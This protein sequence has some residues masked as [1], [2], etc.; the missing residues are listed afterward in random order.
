MIRTVAIFSWQD[1]VGRVA[2]R[3]P[4]PWIT[5]NHGARGATRPTLTFMGEDRAARLFVLLVAFCF[6]LTA[7]PLVINSQRVHLRSGD[8]PEWQEFATQTPNGRRLDLKF[9]ASSNRTE[10]TLFIRQ[11]EVRQDWPVELN[12]R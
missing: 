6:S 3:A 5:L 1:K 4:L 9:S 12:G 11:D 10:A 2:P 7:A 8:T